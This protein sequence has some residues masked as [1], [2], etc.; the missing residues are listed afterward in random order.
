M[1]REFGDPYKY[2][3][4]DTLRNKPG[5]RDADAL[6]V[7]EYEQAASRT[8]E[9]RSQP[10]QG[11]F[12]LPHMDA[13]HGHLFQ[14][15]YEWAGKTRTVNISKG[16]SAFAQ[17]AFVESEGKRLGAALVAENHLRGLDKPRFVERLA[18]HFADWNALHPFREGNGRT[19]REFFHE[20]AK[21]AGYQIDHQV[22]DRDKARWNNAC[23]MSFHGR[24]GPLK[25][26]FN[27]AVTQ[28]DRAKEISSVRPAA[29]VQVPKASSAQLSAILRIA[30]ERGITPQAPSPGLKTSS[31]DRGPSR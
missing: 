26:I 15:V 20:L 30:R 8:K 24:M 4:T 16:N 31:K 22:I 28:L 12:D 3:G 17:P 25:E 13:I 18:E 29:A 14:D 2:P 10:V 21:Q 11:R 23:A 9:L 7:Y 19:T 6:Q 5:I 27:E 1:T